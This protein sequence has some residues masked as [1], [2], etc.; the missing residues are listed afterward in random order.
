MTPPVRPAVLADSPGITAVMAAVWPDEAPDETL[1][2]AALVD[3]DHAAFVVESP[4][5]RILAFAD[6]FLTRDS[7]GTPRWEF[8]LLATRPGAQGRGL[9]RAL[10][11]VCTAEGSQRGARYCRSLIRIDNVASETVFSRCG[12][13]V[14]ETVLALLVREGRPLAML[15]GMAPVP[16]RT[17]RYEGIWLE[18]G[19]EEQAG[20]RYSLGGEIAGVLL[21]EDDG[22]A[23]GRAKAAGFAPG[24]LF[25]W[26][27]LTW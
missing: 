11:T 12:F 13:A 16:V 20:D 7:T 17:F 19:Q 22:A 10:V 15:P 3:P 26:W 21:P 2:C 9:G 24:G 18:P 5:G 25:R 23:L 1:V 4:D 6:G 27:R 8:D 14:A